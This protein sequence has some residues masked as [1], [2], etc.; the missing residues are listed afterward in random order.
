MALFHSFAYDWNDD[1][2]DVVEADND[3]DDEDEDDNHPPVFSCHTWLVG[4][5]SVPPRKQCSPSQNVPHLHT[6]FHLHST[7]LAHNFQWTC[8]QT[9]TCTV[10]LHK[11]LPHLHTNFHT[12]CTAQSLLLHTNFHL[13][14]T[15]TV[16][17]TPL[18]HRLLQQLYRLHWHKSTM[19]LACMYSKAKQT[20]CSVPAYNSVC[21]S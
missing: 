16:T 5:G 3:E 1:D 14:T 6:N 9:S 7:P 18:A 21:T 19:P 2:D 20:I 4:R 15:C 11:L 13:H 10:L 17:F 8:T 12:T